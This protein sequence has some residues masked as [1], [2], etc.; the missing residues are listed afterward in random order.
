M[1]QLNTD[2]EKFQNFKS[3][4][5][6]TFVA[7]D[8]D[9]P[10]IGDR[11][12]VIVAAAI[13]VPVVDGVDNYRLPSQSQQ[14]LYTV[15]G[16]I[17]TLSGQFIYD[18]VTLYITQCPDT[19]HIVTLYNLTNT[20]KILL[21]KTLTISLYGI[22]DAKETIHDRRRSHIKENKSNSDIIED[23]EKQRLKSL[24]ILVGKLGTYN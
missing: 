3:T 14:S 13:V 15:T 1:G 20:S 19:Q 2:N 4:S 8:F 9:M 17:Q 11:I 10:N 6:F 18:L 5:S 24:L 23:A 12:V 21:Q 16:S 7:I 22:K